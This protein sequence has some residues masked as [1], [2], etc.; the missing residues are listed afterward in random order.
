MGNGFR[1]TE[2]LLEFMVAGCVV[3]VPMRIYNVSELQIVLFY[4]LDD[5]MDV[6][7]GVNHCRFKCFHVGYEVA[8]VFAVLLYL[9]E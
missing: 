5:C 9:I 3:G 6:V 1:C 8:E 4:C 7:A 2:G